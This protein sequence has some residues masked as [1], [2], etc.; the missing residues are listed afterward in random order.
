MAAG[1]AAPLVMPPAVTLEVQARCLHKSE[2]SCC[3]QDD[4]ARSGSASSSRRSACSTLRLGAVF[5]CV[6]YNV[7]PVNV[8]PPKVADHGGQ[9]VPEDVIANRKIS[10]ECGFFAAR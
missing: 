9:L 7:R 1:W 3:A 10:A 5:T 8:M 6:V 2:R 4:T